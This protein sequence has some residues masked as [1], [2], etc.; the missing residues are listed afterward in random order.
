MMGMVALLVL[1]SVPVSAHTFNMASHMPAHMVIMYSMSWFG[2]PYNDANGGGPDPLWNNYGNWNINLSPATCPPINDANLANCSIY[3]TGGP[4]VINNQPGFAYR[5]ATPQRQIGS[6]RRPLAG[7]Y[8][9]SGKDLESQAR[10][11]LQLSLIRQTCFTRGPG[12]NSVDA[13]LDAWCVQQNSVYFSSNYPNNYQC[14][15]CEIAWSALQQFYIQAQAGGMTNVV[16]P[17]LDGTWIFGFG[18]HHGFTTQAQQMAVLQSD[19]TDMLTLALQYPQQT[20]I[21]NG[22]PLLYV[23]VDTSLS[24]SQWNTTFN[25]VR[26]ATGH[27]FYVLG[28]IQ[29]GAYFA[30]F[31]ALTPWMGTAQ[32]PTDAATLAKPL[33]TQAVA[34]MG[35]MHSSLTSTVASYPGRAVWGFVSVKTNRAQLGVASVSV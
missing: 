2:L 30:A 3:G 10:I 31:D 23:Y 17:G 8:S 34:W 22:I 15:T 35:A 9:S 24:P 13:G 11:T 18:P 28:S 25:N 6:K 29:N 4:S 19:I 5:T 27:D 21:I 26:L 33:E 32:W 16:L 1:L 14:T 7:I 12:G 20:V